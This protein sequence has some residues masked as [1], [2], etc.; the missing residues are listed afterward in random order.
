MYVFC[1]FLNKTVRTSKDFL[2]RVRVA[3]PASFNSKRDYAAHQ[4]VL[5]GIRCLEKPNSTWWQPNHGWSQESSAP[6][7]NAHRLPEQ[8]WPWHTDRIQFLSMV[9]LPHPIKS[10]NAMSWVQRGQCPSASGFA[11]ERQN[12]RTP[13]TAPDTI[14]RPNLQSLE[15]ASE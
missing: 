6:C 3:G 12:K 7:T 5:M 4:V 2:T 14:L 9:L 15:F 8:L 10:Q 13:R 1:D 11:Q